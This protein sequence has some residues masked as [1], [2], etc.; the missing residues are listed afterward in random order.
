VVIILL[1][2]MSA[3]VAAVIVVSRGQR[4]RHPVQNAAR[5]AGQWPDP[6]RFDPRF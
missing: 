4:D 3:L 5:R 6:Y 1:L 2:A